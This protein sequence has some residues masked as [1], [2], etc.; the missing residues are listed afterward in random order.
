[1][2]EQLPEVS[3]A[4]APPDFF[5]TLSYWALVGLAAGFVLFFYRS[6]RDDVL[7]SRG[8]E[9]IFE[10]AAFQ[11]DVTGPRFGEED[12]LGP[13][14]QAL[15]GA[16]TAAQP[17]QRMEER[18]GD[19]LL[20][21]GLHRE[22]ADYYL[23]ALTKRPSAHLAMQAG[24]AA[25]AA[26]DTEI[27]SEAYGTWIRLEPDNPLPYN[28]LGYYYAVQGLQ[29]AEAEALV[30]R[31]LELVPP[32]DALARANILDS[33]AWVYHR[34]QRRREAY[35]KMQEVSAI[36]AALHL[37][38]DDIVRGHYDEIATEMRQGRAPGPEATESETG[39]V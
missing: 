17:G 20:T 22:A 19:W 32:K 25:C 35:E 12:Y 33:L 1:V 16:C 2:D 15:D 9:A 30:G 31:A 26:G 21:K 7:A 10:A 36:Y 11:Y 38:M 28:S 27:A 18:V 5:R 6:H 14:L 37:R 34:Q 24:Q 39:S 23:R 4:P 29:L 13:V 8:A 3:P